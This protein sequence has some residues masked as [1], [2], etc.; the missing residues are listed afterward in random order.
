MNGLHLFKAAQGMTLADQFTDGPLVQGAR[1]QQNNV[2]DHV[3]IAANNSLVNKKS[4][5]CMYVHAHTHTY[6][7]MHA[8]AHTHTHTVTHAH[9]HTDTKMK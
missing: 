1:D 5:L 3:P 7:H 9:T 8:H 6:I 4:S 2:V